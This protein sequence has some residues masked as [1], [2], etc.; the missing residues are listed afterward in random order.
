MSDSILL[1]TKKALGIAED[2]DV[3]DQNLIMFINGVFSTLNQI[4]IGP[5]DGF[6]IEDDASTWSEY[7][8]VNVQYNSVKTYM[9]L[10]VRI[11]FD[12]P[13]TSFLIDAITKQ[14]EELEWRL[15][16]LRESGRWIPVTSVLDGGNAGP[17]F[18]DVDINIGQ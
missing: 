5:A 4:G 7:I 10:R 8:G 6:E 14:K 15:S 1:T 12:P 3:F 17:R 9:Y 11:L 16:V 2:Y 18:D 13:T